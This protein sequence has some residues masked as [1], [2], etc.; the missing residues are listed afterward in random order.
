MTLEVMTKKWQVTPELRKRI[1]EIRRAIEKEDKEFE[2]TP[3]PCPQ[4][5]K[6]GKFVRYD[7]AYTRGY[8]VF[9]CPEGHEFQVG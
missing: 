8:A 5:N 9:R 6:P 3:Q 7:G 4:H 2:K 1:A